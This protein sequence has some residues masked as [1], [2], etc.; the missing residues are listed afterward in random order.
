[1]GT[2]K[3]FLRYSGEPQARL[4]A[5]VLSAVVD[6]VFISVSNEQPGNPDLAGL[7]LLVDDD[8]SIGPLGGI[9][10]AFRHD[11][12]AAWLV[13]AVDMP[14]ITRETLKRLVR[15]RDPDAPATAY[16]S[17]V[18]GEPEPVCAIYEPAILPLLEEGRA[19][20]RFSLKLLL[21]LPVKLI[22]PASLRELRNVN[23]PAE[24]QAWLKGE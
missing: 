7:S 3:A 22:D 20:G 21:T 6:D 8:K 1:M 2:D 13:A 24:Y 11:P 18:T 14:G 23:D 10:R 16:K 9:L 19:A 15:A 4:L 5:A 17:P 12:R